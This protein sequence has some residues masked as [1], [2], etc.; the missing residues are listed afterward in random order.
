[1]VCRPSALMEE[2]ATVRGCKMSG[3]DVARFQIRSL[4]INSKNSLRR[5]ISPL[6]YYRSDII[7]LDVSV[8]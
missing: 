4:I 7:C 5:Q 2:E 3:Y 8:T 1:M 6:R